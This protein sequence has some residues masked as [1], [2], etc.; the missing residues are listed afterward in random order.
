MKT[1]IRQICA[2]ALCCALVGVSCKSSDKEKTDPA[3][4]KQAPTPGVDVFVVTP[5]ALGQQMEVPG[6]L[7]AN[8]E[9]EIHP[10]VSGRVIGLFI[11]EGTAVAKGALLAKL[12]DADLQAQLRKLQVQLTIA[13][14]TE[15][16]QKQ[17]LAVNG[18]SQQDYDLSLLSVNNLLADID[19][20]KTAIAKTEVRAPFSGTLGLRNISLGAFVTNATVL[21]TLRDFNQLKLEFTVPERYGSQVHNGGLVHFL[22]DGNAQRFAASVIAT[23]NNIAADTRSLRVKALVNQKAAALISG[24]F[25]KVQLDM[26]K[27]DAALMVPTQ[28]IIPQARNKKVVV[29]RN[30]LTSMEV[31]TTGIRDTSKVEITS[32]LKPGDTIL[33][34]GLLTTKPGSK[35][36]IKSIQPTQKH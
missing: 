13:Q 11:K 18:I 27:N 15:D 34:S 20:I 2:L 24:A 21:T 35:V 23:E 28:A 9:T 8:E 6:S 5:Q 29:L 32:G 1:Q 22:I 12:Y 36:K 25:A 31:V 26:G 16:R 4:S 3:K 33:I 10:E 19:I 17:L 14:K 30:G 7:L